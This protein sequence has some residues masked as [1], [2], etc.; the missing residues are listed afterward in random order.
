MVER[1]YPHRLHRLLSEKVLSL[2]GQ[3]VVVAVVVEWELCKLFLQ[4][5]QD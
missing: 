4:S 1:I 5:S 3:Q 2:A